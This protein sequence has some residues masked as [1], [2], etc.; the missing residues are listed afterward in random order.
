[1]GERNGYRCEAV[2]VE[3]FAQQLAAYIAVGYWFYVAGQIPERKNPEAVDRKLIDR[4][5]IGI[6]KWARA[7]R[8]R[9]GGANV[10][11]LRYGRFF[12]L[13]ATKGVHR[14]FQDEP[15]FKD[16][17]RA[18]LRFKGY[19]IGC[20]RGNDGRLHASVRI[21]IEEY[22][23]LKRYFQERACRLS[24][25]RLALGLSRI[26]FAPFARVRRQSLNILRAVNRGRHAAGLEAVPL[27]ALR[28][29]R[30]IVRVFAGEIEGGEGLKRVG[31]AF[32]A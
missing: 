28:L 1:M 27:S 7:R 18:P 15:R 11:Y 9:L 4:F 29:R 16:F 2:S 12:V 21:H 19:F 10:Q 26:S 17:R 24:S 22:L 31:C 23:K 14:F 25:E 3:G 20:G 30:R 13:V 5:D 6:S 8:K 32:P